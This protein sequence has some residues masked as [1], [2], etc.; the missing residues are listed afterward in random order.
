MMLRRDFI[1]L[2]GAASAAVLLPKAAGSAERPSIKIATGVTPPSIYNIWLH[3][4]YDRGFF[5]DNGVDVADFIQLRGGPLAIQAMAAGEADLAPADPEGLFAAVV[6]GHPIR[7][8]AAP[9]SRLAYMVVV[10]RD[11]ETLLDLSGKPFAISRPGA[12]SQYLMFPLLDSVGVSRD[13]IEWLAVGSNSDRL[14]ALR[15]DR[16][17]GAL[18]NIDAAMEAAKDPALKLIKSVT[19]ILPDYPVELLI[20]RKEMIDSDPE[21]AAAVT[22]AVIQACRFIVADKAGTIETVLKYAPGMDTAVL[23]R[24]YDE[25][26]R[27]RGF[28]VNGGMTTV[29]LKAAHDL[30]LQNGQI[31]HPVALDQCADFRFQDRALDAL[32]RAPG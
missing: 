32:G 3:V 18:L 20:L 6:A 30:A 1:S 31:K 23:E 21:T 4:A 15:A 22:K 7:A 25:L 17:K 8:V 13:A 14:L 24:A 26:I 16:V 29:N 5:S 11:I 9:G 2:V 28:G 19:D 27:I 10:R 12:I